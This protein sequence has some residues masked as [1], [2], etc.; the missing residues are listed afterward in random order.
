M[1]EYTK[2][3]RWDEKTFDI[4]WPI[5]PKII[6]KKDLTYPSFND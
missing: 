6:S 4:K 5:N 2:G 3:I 1:P